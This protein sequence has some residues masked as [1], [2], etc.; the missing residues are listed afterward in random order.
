[1]RGN[2]G[3]ARRF[4][5]DVSMDGDGSNTDSGQGGSVEGDK[6]A[7]R[8]YDVSGCRYDLHSRPAGK[9]ADKSTRFV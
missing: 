2:N 6:M 9:T 1:M 8:H 4:L 5:E 3:E 7:M